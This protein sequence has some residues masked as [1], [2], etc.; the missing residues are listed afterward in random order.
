MVN[1]IILYY[2]TRS[3]KHK[4]FK[5]SFINT[6]VRNRIVKARELLTKSALSLHLQEETEWNKVARKLDY[7][8]KQIVTLL[9]FELMIEKCHLKQYCFQELLTLV[10]KLLLDLRL[11]GKRMADFFIWRIIYFFLVHCME[12]Y[13]SPLLR[14]WKTATN[15]LSR[16]HCKV[17]NCEYYILCCEVYLF[18]AISRILNPSALISVFH[19]DTQLQILRTLY[20]ILQHIS[21]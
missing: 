7:R 12:D 16:I 8:R 13:L 1:E 9:C 11:T 20:Q 14:F 15:I 3:K 2:D 4:I 6:N 21:R 17:R 5:N 10:S 19:G 18:P